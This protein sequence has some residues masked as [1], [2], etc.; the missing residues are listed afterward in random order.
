MSDDFDAALDAQSSQGPQDTST[1]FGAALDAR[2]SEGAIVSKTPEYS[3]PA[4]VVASKI[5]NIGEYLPKKVM[6][7]F[8]GLYDI[9]SGQGFQRADQEGAER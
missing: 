2:A 9:A 8:H 5:V 4:D 3:S 7:G 6:A 1:A